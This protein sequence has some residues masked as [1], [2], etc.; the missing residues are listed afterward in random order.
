MNIKE[1][2]C[3]FSS[4]VSVFKLSM[5][6]GHFLVVSFVNWWLFRACSTSIH[7][8]VFPIQHSPHSITSNTGLELSPF[9]QNCNKSWLIAVWYTVSVSFSLSR[10]EST[11]MDNTTIPN[12]HIPQVNGVMEHCCHPHSLH[13]Y[14]S[15]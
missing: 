4:L 1:S 9:I 3:R 14:Y 8:S 6:C 11:A 7:F 15:D 10:G 5:G 12:Y 13:P 2:N